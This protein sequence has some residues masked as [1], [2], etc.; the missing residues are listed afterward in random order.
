VFISREHSHCPNIYKI[1]SKTTRPL[2][3]A[4]GTTSGVVD[5][6][7]VRTGTS[8]LPSTWQYGTTAVTSFTWYPD[9]SR[10][11]V[12]HKDGL[13]DFWDIK[14]GKQLPPVPKFNIPVPLTSVGFSPNGKEFAVGFLSGDVCTGDIG[15]LAQLGHCPK[16]TKDYSHWVFSQM[17][18]LSLLKSSQKGNDNFIPP[19]ESHIHN[20]GVE[21][22]P[23]ITSCLFTQSSDNKLPLT[24]FRYSYDQSRVA[25]GYGTF[26]DYTGGT[27]EIRDS[28]SGEL[29]FEPIWHLHP[30]LSIDFSHDRSKIAIATSLDQGTYS[31]E[32]HNVKIRDINVDIPPFLQ[33]LTDHISS[34]AFSPDGCQIALGDVNGSVSIYDTKKGTLSLKTT[35]LHPK[36]ITALEFSPNGTQIVSASPGLIQ[37]WDTASGS[38][39]TTVLL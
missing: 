10:I 25:L 11:G 34:S 30:V 22:L 39:C 13:V 15:D 6:F 38:V 37:M 35:P 36:L 19:W 21:L 20:S 24:S 32:H 18:S 16:M 5:I 26:S 28:L 23:A 27:V 2:Q 33:P 31:R 3:I 8:L 17:I 14:S 12:G 7:D 9:S 4:T 29:L 1:H